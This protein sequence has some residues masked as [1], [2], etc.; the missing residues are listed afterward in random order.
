MTPIRAPRLTC[1]NAEFVGFKYN[2]DVCHRRAMSRRD[3][4]VC[5]EARYALGRRSGCRRA[6]RLCAAGER[7]M[8]FGDILVCMDDSA[9]GRRRTELALNLAM[10]S[11]RSRHRLLSQAAPRSRPRRSS[12]TRRKPSSSKTRPR[13]SSASSDCAD[14][15]E[16][17]FSAAIRT[18]PRTLP[19]YARCA[20]LVVAGLGFPD[21]PSS[22][23]QNLDIEQ[24][25]IECAGPVLG[26]PIT[27]GSDEI[28]RNVMVA[29]DGSREA[30]RA[31]R[32]A[33]P[34]LREAATV[35]LVSIERNS[36]RGRVSKRCGR[37]SAA[38]GY[39]GID[40]LPRSICTCPWAKKY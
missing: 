34:F 20:D 3:G 32:D 18:L 28:G 39:H 25:V 13:T 11:R 38:S 29:W 7:A 2:I 15:K 21:D 4:Q 16:P 10:R 37:S 31:L 26:I 40:R 30:S 17:G 35:R 5:C 33:I 24:L 9:T 22:D 19:N 23:P 1:L 12:S 27:S 36:N 6:R 8:Q 14:W